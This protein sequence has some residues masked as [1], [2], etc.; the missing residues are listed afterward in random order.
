MVMPDDDL[1][2]AEFLKQGKKQGLDEKLLREVL[3]HLLVNQ[4]HPAG[5]REHIRSQLQRII[6][7]HSKG[8]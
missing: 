1:L 7:Q 3:A 8:D 4:F 2:I 6:K 5:E